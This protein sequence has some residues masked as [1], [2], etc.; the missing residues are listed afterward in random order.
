MDTHTGDEPQSAGITANPLTLAPNNIYGIEALTALRHLPADSVDCI[1]TSPPYWACRDY[2]VPPV[3]WRDG[4]AV[5]LGL[6]TSPVAYVDHLCEVFE[7]S[8][9]VLK[10]S[11]TLWVN[12]GDVYWLPQRV[13]VVRRAAGQETSRPVAS[14][15]SLRDCGLH[16][17][18]LCLIPERFALAMVARGWILRNRIAWYKPN[19]MPSTA[20]D[21]FACSWEYLFFFTKS[22]RYAFDL[23]AVRIDH[24]TAGPRH[25]RA[26]V[27]SKQ[28]SRSLIGLR[29]GPPH[30]D[31]HARH[32]N[33]GN[34]GDC[35]MIPT[36]PSGRGHPAPFPEP[37]IERPILA[38]CPPG[39]TV[40]DPFMGSGTTAVVAQRLGRQFLGFEANAAF[41]AIA[42]RRAG[43]TPTK[44]P[45]GSEVPP[46]RDP[47]VH[48]TEGR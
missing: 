6:E 30:G 21:R 3:M 8:R 33:G 37:L 15:D 16:E 40:L 13:H 35:W 1:V 11:G 32:V 47:R 7:E 19:H 9:R 38:G 31:P 24:K 28:S 39:G 5:P 42:R 46:P 48:S 29:F 34:P 27:P 10:D 4:S 36:R 20:R 12:L 25:P 41:A 23:D 22:P 43:L 26:M 44:I 14:P 45:S 17:K 2:G 18:S